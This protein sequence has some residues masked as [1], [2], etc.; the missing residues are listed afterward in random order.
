[1]VGVADDAL[2][3]RICAV[4]VGSG[5]ALDLATLRG[6]LADRGLASFK[7]PDTVRR[8]SSL[9]LTAVGK[10]DKAALRRDLA[11]R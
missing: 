4:V 2:G 6:Y 10:V 7:L 9:P 8:V 1:M 11:T 5:D 3:E